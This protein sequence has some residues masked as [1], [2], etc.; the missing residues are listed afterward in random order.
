MDIKLSRYGLFRVAS[1][2]PKLK[3]GDIDYNIGEIKALIN[4]AND[5]K[6][7]MIVF[8]EL[9]ITGY[10]MGDLFFQDR[11]IKASYEG[12]Q[13]II[14]YSL[15]LD[16]IIVV[17]NQLMVDNQMFNC[18]FIIYK[19]EILGI[20][21]K[22]HIPNYNEFYEKRWFESSTNAVREKVDFLNYK[23]IPFHTNILIEDETTGAVIGTEICEDLWV[24]IPPS[25]YHSLYG[26]NIIVNLSA[27]NEII[28]KEQ[29]RRD[30][31]TQ[32]SARTIG[33]YIYSSASRHE[34]TSDIVFSNHLLIAENG[35]LLSEKTFDL[36]NDNKIIYADIDVEKLKHE[37]VVKNSFMENLPKLDYKRVKIKTEDK[38]VN[39]L[40]RKDITGDIF[41]TKDYDSI[42][43]IVDIQTAGLMK[44][45]EHIG[46]KNIVV[47][48]SGGLDSTLALLIAV[49]CF[50]NMGLPLKN[51]IAITMPGFGTTGRTYNNAV[52]MIKGLGATFK[53][54]SIKAATEQHFKDINHDENKHD[55]VYE[56]SQA[57]E[58]TKILMDVANQYNTIVLGTGNL[59]EIALGWCTY[60]ADHMSMYA[61]NGSIPKSLVRNMISWIRDEMDGLKTEVR[62]A[63]TD[64][65]DTPI[66]PELLP[67]SETGEILQKTESVIGDYILHDFFL[68]YMVRHGF[69]PKK[70]LLYATIGFEGRY[71]KAEI[72]KW[73]IMFLK[74]FFNNQFKRNCMPDSVKVGSVSLSPRGDWR[75]PSDALSKIW[76]KEL[77]EDELS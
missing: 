26:A 19:G 1:A 75:M 63:L 10:T 21:P 48:I 13:K 71:E 28:G 43:K 65:L 16:L 66:S 35:R 70:I 22:T 30:L 25:L 46:C 53:E 11:V 27:S 34:S 2:S 68:Y 23:D 77:E 73:L 55:I 58:R 72:K 17:G 29:Y 20:V 41:V 7:N 5:K 62:E 57:R 9:A 56:N 18:G 52:A 50:N 59:S 42:K 14:D 4:D 33:S 39:K 60:N 8:P 31:V 69:S 51:I 47:G 61:V 45:M 64:I 38:I 3:V 74:R 6:T 44:R 67:A 76:L 36:K 24:P 37:R 12:V 15:D 32:Q 54:I 40:L 49:N